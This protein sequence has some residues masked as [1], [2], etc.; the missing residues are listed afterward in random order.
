M[1]SLRRFGSLTI[2]LTKNAVSAAT[3]PTAIQRVARQ[4]SSVVPSGSYSMSTMMQDGASVADKPVESSIRRKLEEFFEPR[5]LDVLN[6]SGM[7]AVPKGSETHFKVIVVSER[8]LN[9]PLINR[10]R[11]VNKVLEAE[12]KSGLHALS[13]I[14]KTRD[15]W[16]GSDKI[17]DK[18]PPCRGGTGL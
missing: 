16:E 4:S 18:S 11:L 6:E 12:F 5:Y 3:K 10:H 14:A 15:Q 1:L 7:H 13:I 8:F 9:E 2:G 17:V